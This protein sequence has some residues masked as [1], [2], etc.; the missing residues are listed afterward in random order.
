MALRAI[1]YYLQGF[2]K[3]LKACWRSWL[4][5]QSQVKYILSVF[6]EGTSQAWTNSSFS[7]SSLKATHPST[8]SQVISFP[9]WSFRS[10]SH[11]KAEVT[12]I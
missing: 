3:G 2:I 4:V 1:D 5:S 6:K 11:Y 9:Y 10:Y 8:Y 7:S 12:K